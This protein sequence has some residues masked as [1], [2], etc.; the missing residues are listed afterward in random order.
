MG[1][2]FVLGR[3]NRD[4]RGFMLD[5]IATILATNRKAKVF[6]LVPD[7]IKF[8]AEMTVLEKIGELPPFNENKM[9]GMM[10]LQV[11]SFNRLAWYWLQDTDTFIKPQL[12]TSG[13][14]MLVRKLLIEFEEQLVIYRGEVRKTGF[15]QQLTDLFLE[16]RTGRIT[17]D[18]LAVLVNHLGSSPQEV[19]F[20]LKLKDISL[21]YQAFDASLTGKYIETEDILTALIKKLQEKDLSETTI[22]IESYFRFTA[23]EQALILA[24]MKAAKKV[25]IALTSDKAYAVEKPEMHNLFQTSGATYYKLY[26]LARQNNVPVYKDKL[27]QE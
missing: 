7:H 15:V 18:D 13:L 24:L 5:E 6:Y 10:N 27:I 9:M 16:L 19:D 1:L 11:F 17:Q 8:E 21:L 22:Y 26:Q 4:K 3:A 25:T 23:Q 12:T 2:Q 14:S 20:Q